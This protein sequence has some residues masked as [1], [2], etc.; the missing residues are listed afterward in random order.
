MEVLQVGDLFLAPSRDLKSNKE[1][2]TKTLKWGGCGGSSKS[3][4]FSFIF[5][6]NV[7]FLRV[8][9]FPHYTHLQTANINNYKNKETRPIIDDND[10][11]KNPGNPNVVFLGLN[12]MN[13]RYGK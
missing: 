5:L 3:Y 1:D 9:Q 11:Y 10:Q 4:P 2:E 7:V 8:S 6:F 12:R 13:L